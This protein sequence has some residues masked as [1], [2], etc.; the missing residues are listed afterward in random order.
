MSR[1]PSARELAA[2]ALAAQ[3]VDP[4]AA[5]IDAWLRESNERVRK[6]KEDAA[7]VE[8][9]VVRDAGQTPAEV[10]SAD[11]PTVPWRP[12]EEAGV[13]D[14]DRRHVREFF[15][16]SEAA[17]ALVCQSC[18]HRDVMGPRVWGAYAVTSRPSREGQVSAASLEDIGN[19]LGVDPKRVSEAR[20]RLI[21]LDLLSARGVLRTVVRIR[22]CEER[23]PASAGADSRAGGSRECGRGGPA[24]A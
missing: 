20:Q 6:A 16:L 12:L 23:I 21:N 7:R 3:G 13:V 11:A 14:Y 15:M 4:S 9:P 10:A 22:P 19:L 17:W 5:A 24:S 2:R 8:A 18:G 1:R